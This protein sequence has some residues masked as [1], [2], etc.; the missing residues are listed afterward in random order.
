MEQGGNGQHRRGSSQNEGIA[1]HLRLKIRERASTAGQKAGAKLNVGFSQGL[2]RTCLRGVK[3]VH[4]LSGLREGRKVALWPTVLRDPLFPE[5][6]LKRE[7]D[8]D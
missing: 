3:R 4:S 8:R 6:L 2:G 1:T 5:S 7:Q